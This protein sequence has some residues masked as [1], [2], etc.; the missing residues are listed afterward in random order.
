MNWSE[1]QE[2][3][4]DVDAERVHMFVLDFVR[5]RKML[6]RFVHHF[7]TAV[8]CRPLKR[9][10]LVELFWGLARFG[11]EG[12]S[13]DLLRD[14]FFSLMFRAPKFPNQ[15]SMHLLYLAY[16][17]G[18]FT[19][20]EVIQ[21]IRKFCFENRYAQENI[22]VILQWWM[23]EL[24]EGFPYFVKSH[25]PTK[26]KSAA[27]N[28]DVIVEKTRKMSREEVN[29]W[30]RNGIYMG[31]IDKILAEDDVDALQNVVHTRNLSPNTQIDSLG[32]R[33]ASVLEL[34]ALNSAI[35]CFKFL[36]MHDQTKIDSS[37]LEFAAAGG[38]LEII[39]ILEEKIPVS[40]RAAVCAAEMHQN[41]VLQWII[42]NHEFKG[43]DDQ[44]LSVLAQASKSN[45]IAAV[46]MCLES[47]LIHRSNET[48]NALFESCYEN[49]EEIVEILLNS[50]LVDINECVP[51][52]FSELF[53]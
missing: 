19:K 51:S 37:A 1:L 49:N 29:Q 46:T 23:P 24:S 53:C 30:R 36:M 2:C 43:Y 17:S 16:E 3:L 21:G 39:R 20:E 33:S 6:E 18:H 15:V 34:A 14:V 45:N 31:E 47:S 50:G 22:N 9:Q 27:H 32:Y 48:V 7:I 10:M 41:D 26:Q 38:N 35:K 8:T 25:W 44:G 5:D 52:L 4:N 28:L 13:L 11:D 40:Y 42:E 12:P